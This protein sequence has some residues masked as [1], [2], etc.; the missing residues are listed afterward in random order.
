MF[1]RKNADTSGE[2]VTEEDAR[3]TLASYV[4]KAEAAQVVE[5]VNNLKRKVRA[6]EALAETLRNSR[7]V[8]TSVSAS[9]RVA[10]PID[11]G[12][13]G[14]RP[15]TAS[16]TGVDYGAVAFGLAQIKSDVTRLVGSSVSVDTSQLTEH[17]RQTVQFFADV[18]AKSDTGFDADAFKRT[19]GA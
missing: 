1:N 8:P 14:S 10:D 9:P 5:D 11:G 17:Y 16:V 3:N 18:F 12:T 19:A 15:R 13:V 2:F 6:L 4:T 7:Q